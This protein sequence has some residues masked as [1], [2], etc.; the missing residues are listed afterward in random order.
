MK[1]IGIVVA[2]LALGIMS[3]ASLAR[4]KSIHCVAGGNCATAEGC[5][6]LTSSGTFQCNGIGT[7]YTYAY[8]AGQYKKVDVAVRQVC[9]NSSNGCENNATNICRT[10]TFSVLS[11]CTESGEG[12][13]TYNVFN[14][15]SNNWC[16]KNFY[17]P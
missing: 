15:T 2:V 10:V 1:R 6:Q 14:C 4:V 17:G 12:S 11:D 9:K 7:S 16:N 8:Y 13:N 3:S 5:H